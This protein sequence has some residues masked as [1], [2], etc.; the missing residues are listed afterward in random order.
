[1]SCVSLGDQRASLDFRN[2]VWTTRG[3]D[4]MIT[5]VFWIR[6]FNLEFVFLTSFKRWYYIS[7]SLDIMI[8]SLFW[9][10]WYWIALHQVQPGFIFGTRTDCLIDLISQKEFLSLCLKKKSISTMSWLF[11]ELLSRARDY[12]QRVINAETAVR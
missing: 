8:V 7:Y 5:K 6:G 12:T 10:T 9:W 2:P 1:M 4:A 11:A 3:L